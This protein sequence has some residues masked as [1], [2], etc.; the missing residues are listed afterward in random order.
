MGPCAP[1]GTSGAL[2]LLLPPSTPSALALR[3]WL[4]IP[5]GLVRILPSVQLPGALP[6]ASGSRPSLL[7]LP[8]TGSGPR[9]APFGTR[10]RPAWRVRSSFLLP[11]PFVRPTRRVRSAPLSPSSWLLPSLPFSSGSLLP[12]RPRA[13][14]I[15]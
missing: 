14:R 1:P 2:L 15:P 13:R 8:S 4:A 3:V 12:P 9:G 11:W 7:P 10:V 6:S 5:V